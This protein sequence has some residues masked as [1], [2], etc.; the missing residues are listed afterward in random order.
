MRSSHIRRPSACDARRLIVFA[1]LLALAGCG[2][3]YNAPPTVRTG[4]PVDVHTR[5]TKPVVVV[6]QFANPPRSP[7]AW[8]DVGRGMS[9]AL[10]RT[11]LNHGSFD[12]WVD[13]AMARHVTAA[14][15]QPVAKRRIALD[16]I[17]REHRRVS[18]VV[19]GRVTDF[20]H[21]T[22]K[23]KEVRRW[24][25]LGRRREAVVALELTVFDLHTGHAVTSDHLVGTARAPRTPTAEL[26]ANMAF[27]EYLFWSTPLGAAS[28]SV[29]ERAMA[30]LDRTVPDGQGVRVVAQLAPR[31][32]RIDTLDPE[33]EPGERYFVC[34]VDPATGD[35]RPVLDADTHRPLTARVE[36]T[37][38]RTDRA[39]LLG[40]RPRAADLTGARLCPIPPVRAPQSASR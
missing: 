23:P 8:D 17:R 38:G 3:S 12:V 25:L 33:A 40:R 34:L 14:M 35:H 15:S 24:G 4:Q 16:R 39:W 30:I 13:D 31:E 5:A 26:Y 11:I 9:E 29:L 32:L 10:A 37:R 6:G 27:G 36:T 21:T 28:E 22:D 19:A 20:T 18:Y 7:L 1:S 2:W